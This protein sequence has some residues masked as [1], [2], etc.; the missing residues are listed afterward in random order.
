MTWMETAIRKFW[1]GQA[2]TAF[3][4]E[5]DGPGQ[6]PDRLIWQEDQIWGNTIA[7]SDSDGLLEI[8]S[9][10]DPGSSGNEGLILFET[11]GND[12][13][14]EGLI[15]SNPT[16]GMNSIA[17]SFAVA[18]FAGN[19]QNAILAG[20]S[21]GRFIHVSIQW[22]QHLFPELAVHYTGTKNAVH[23]RNRR[24]GPSVGR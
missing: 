8:I 6:F 16:D 4:L 23:N 17:T 22:E 2:Q 7:D 24:F 10:N 13:F 5:G 9:R 14:S 20:D 15:L 1:C 11:T 18:D 19:G 12:Q 3:L 21:D